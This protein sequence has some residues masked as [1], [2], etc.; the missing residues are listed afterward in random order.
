VDEVWEMA[1]R[2]K[3]LPLTR[4]L[5]EDHTGLRLVRLPRK[6]G[7]LPKSAFSNFQILARRLARSSRQ[8]SPESCRVNR[9]WLA[10]V[11]VKRRHQDAARSLTKG[12]ALAVIVP[13]HRGDGIPRMDEVLRIV[14]G[15]E[16]ARQLRPRLGPIVTLLCPCIDSDQGADQSN[17]LLLRDGST[18]NVSFAGG[19]AEK[20][21]N[22]LRRILPGTEFSPL[23]L[24]QLARTID[25]DPDVFKARLLLRWFDDEHLTLWQPSTADSNLELSLL[26]QISAAGFPARIAPND[27]VP[28]PCVSATM[29][30]GKIERLIEKLH[31]P[32]EA[33]LAGEVTPAGIVADIDEASLVSKLKLAKE[34]VLSSV[35]QFEMALNDLSFQPDGAMAKALTTV[36]IG[37]GKLQSKLKKEAANVQDVQRK[38]AERS[39]NY[40]LPEGRPQQETMSLLHYLDFYGVD[41]L[42]GL[43]EV[44]QV[45]D[46]R[47]QTVYLAEE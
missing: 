3:K 24:D 11:G 13:L 21:L 38:Q 35:L 22:R 5:G 20:Y 36:D 12:E 25:S 42:D 8:A 14:T 47:H 46:V 2:V 44:L 27:P 28:F 19:D 29:V 41:F 23:L 1:Y 16:L 40:L 32:V 7:K 39:G 4:A 26:A 31:A 9:D 45:D 6:K 10:K 37:F 43:R 34:Q 30:E 17:I 18:K 33:L 15:L